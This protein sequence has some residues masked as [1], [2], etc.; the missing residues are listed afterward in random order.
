MRH[1]VPAFCIWHQT[2][3]QRASVRSASATPIL[4]FSISEEIGMLCTSVVGPCHILVNAAS[5]LP[6]VKQDSNDLRA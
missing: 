6:V 1:A 3:K 2:L 5:C 4:H